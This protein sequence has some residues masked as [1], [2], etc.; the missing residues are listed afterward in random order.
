[1]FSNCA[2]KYVGAAAVC[3]FVVWALIDVLCAGASYQMRPSLRWILLPICC[4]LFDILGEHT[5][6]SLLS[7]FSSCN[8][9]ISRLT[10]SVYEYVY[11]RRDHQHEI[12]FWIC[13]FRAWIDDIQC[14]RAVEW[15]FSRTAHSHKYTAYGSPFI[16]LEP[17]FQLIFRESFQFV[18]R[19]ACGR[20]T[21]TSA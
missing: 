17:S 21:I 1:M 6:P 7:L 11:E 4:L 14:A 18:W 15:N 10:C 16:K 9:G 2:N 20:Y 13:Y 12:D 19:M 3:L 5:E 8:A